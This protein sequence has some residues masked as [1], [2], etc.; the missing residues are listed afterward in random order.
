MITFE[1]SQ[2][3]S[4]T[5]RLNPTKVEWTYNLNTKVEQ[6][7]GGQVIQ[8]LSI[9][10]DQLILEGRF[11]KEGPHGKV[12]KNQK[13]VDTNS[14]QLWEYGSNGIYATGLTQMTS[15]FQDFFQIASQGN[16]QHINPGLHYDQEPMIVTYGGSLDDNA[17]PSGERQWKVY[18][19]DFPS[20][21]RAL[22]E[23]APQWRVVFEIEQEDYDIKVATLEYELNNFRHNIGY[24]QYWEFSDP[25]FNFLKL[26]GQAI[27][28]K[29]V[30]Q[31]EKQYNDVVTKEFGDINEW[32]SELSSSDYTS[33]ILNGGSAPF[34]YNADGSP[35]I[36]P[37]P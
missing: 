10:F 32:L 15:F 25:I 31:A 5:L 8:I 35:N 12:T 16:D 27:T 9:N 1:H 4:L 7:Y 30:T 6:T 36:S 13:L 17:F 24:Q 22:E 18:P 23:F 14:S 11:G 2:L 34:I 26:N 37:S 21:S 3:K 20:Y 28:Q 33:L 29:N 19:I